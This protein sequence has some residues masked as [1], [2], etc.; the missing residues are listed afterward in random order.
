MNAQNEHH[1]P[2]R[3]GLLLDMHGSGRGVKQL[4]PRLAEDARIQTYGDDQG[5]GH[6]EENHEECVLELKLEMNDFF[7][8]RVKEWEKQF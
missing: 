5:Q 3:L 4:V 7:N 1:H 2:G 6:V 8:I